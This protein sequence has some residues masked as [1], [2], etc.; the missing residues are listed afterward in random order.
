MSGKREF[1]VVLMG[2]MV[3]L[4]VLVVLKAYDVRNPVMLGAGMVVGL[5]SSFVVGLCRS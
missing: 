4:S 1:V 5:A 3:V 2:V